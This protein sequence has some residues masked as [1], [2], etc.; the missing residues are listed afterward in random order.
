MVFKAKIFILLYLLGEKDME[1][2]TSEE[3]SLKM[4]QWMFC[5]SSTPNIVASSS[6]VLLDYKCKDSTRTQIT[7]ISKSKAQTKL[8]LQATLLSDNRWHRCLYSH[9]LQ[10]FYHALLLFFSLTSSLRLYQSLCLSFFHI[11]TFN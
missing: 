10:V 7:I 2:N 11:H 4:V 8:K 5:V 1:K 9:H 6:H 3:N